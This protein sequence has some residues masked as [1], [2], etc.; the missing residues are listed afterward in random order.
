MD[1]PIAESAVTRRQP[2]RVGDVFDALLAR[3]T[4]T[5]R[6]ISAR[7]SGATARIRS[8]LRAS[9]L[10]WRRRLRIICQFGVNALS[11]KSANPFRLALLGRL[12]EGPGRPNKQRSAIPAMAQG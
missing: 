5:A 8:A 7:Q 4:M 1:A 2:P 9:R 12:I 3:R 10:R 11:S 6:R